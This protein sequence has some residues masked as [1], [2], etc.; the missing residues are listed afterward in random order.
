[1]QTQP[2]A[3]TGARVG[4]FARTTRA[5]VFGALVRLPRR[6]GIVPRGAPFSERTA[7]LESVRPRRAISIAAT[8][9]LDWRGNMAAAYDRPEPLSRIRAMTA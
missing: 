3:L 6:L 8:A 5:A 2:R 1:M 4:R 9:A 7:A